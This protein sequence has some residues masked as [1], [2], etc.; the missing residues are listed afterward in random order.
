MW[1]EETMIT[2]KID[3]AQ[4]TQGSREIQ[5]LLGLQDD[6]TNVNKKPFPTEGSKDRGYNN[7]K[8]QKNEQNTLNCPTIA[9]FPRK[10][11]LNTFELWTPAQEMEANKQAENRRYT[12]KND[13]EHKGNA[14]I[15][16]PKATYTDEEL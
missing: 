15:F 5:D 10:S 6:F 11:T 9:F 2:T 13:N 3:I 4:D 1:W 14:T 8:N 7:R 12:S 16:T